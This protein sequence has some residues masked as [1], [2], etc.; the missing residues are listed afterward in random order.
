MTN[1]ENDAM[2]RRTA[3]L[4]VFLLIAL[5]ALIGR[6]GSLT[7]MQQ[8]S[9][10]ARVEG[11]STR[12]IPLPAPRGMI[13][14][15]NMK[16]LAINRPAYRLL[17]HYPYYQETAVVDRLAR[18]LDVTSDQLNRRIVQA[19][20]RPFE[21]V[22]LADD[23]TPAQ[24]TK[25]IEQ[26]LWLP[27]V[28]V[29][30]EPVRQYPMG[31]LAGHLLGY[32]GAV[33]Q[34]EWAELKEEG[35]NA[36]DLIGRVGLE[37]YYESDLRGV[38]GVREILINSAF[39]PLDEVD[40]R[41]P[42]PGRNLVLT[43]DSELQEVTERALDWQM[44]RLQTIP[45]VGD[46]HAYPD[47]RAGAAVVMDVKTGAILA[48]ASR[49]GFDPNLF[50][51][52]ISQ[53]DW[54]RLNGDPFRPMLNRTVQAAYQ[55]GSTWK[56][57]TGATVITAGL[58]NAGEQVFSGS[59][60][61]PTGQ[62]DWLAWGHGWV[63]LVDALRLSSDIYFYEMGA[64]L[65]IERLVEGAKGF[66]FGKETGVDLY[67][68][69]QGFLP[70]KEYREEHGWYLGQTTSAAIG[71]IFTVTPL[72]LA[73]YTA[74]LANGGKLLQPYLVQSVQSADGQV[75]RTTSPREVGTLPI[76]EEARLLAVEGMIRVNLP[77]GTSDF[78]TW[79]LPG[80]ATAGKTG[81]AENPPKD[82]YG[83]FVTFAPVDDPQVAVAVVIEQ[84]G[85]GSSVSPVAR[86]ILASYFGVELPKNDPARLPD[87]PFQ[88]VES[89]DP[90]T[91]R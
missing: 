70:D 38:P 77:G 31:E 62:K 67:E 69:V 13:Y 39:E 4:L 65:G 54:D 78:V 34:E 57:M 80:I 82:D 55:P 14:D 19:Q 53:T 81:T 9:H 72:Q 7:L 51:G 27:G 50:V 47:A 8:K 48:M 73:R 18:V 85:H 22:Q 68:E 44:Y 23:L 11:Q 60:F 12:T 16:P 59:V 63:N 58:T 20:S 61:E 41:R 37:A 43:I 32:V 42:Q 5:T 79:P 88:S 35:Y 64:R 89:F 2:Q 21:P 45:N 75:I 40:L 90:D 3:L 15:R 33:N 36:G 66:G 26:M 87:G 1:R 49:P 86:T 56:M 25:I 28:E 29:R 71:Q 46:G 74:A 91:S 52:G 24:Y 83:L 10:T 76:T 84:A 30:S 17:V 6:L